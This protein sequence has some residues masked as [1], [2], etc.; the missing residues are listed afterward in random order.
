MI[1]IRTNPRQKT[2][3]PND[4]AIEGLDSEKPTTPPATIMLKRPPMPANTPDGHW[5]PT[6]HA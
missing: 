6:F 3:A 2:K 5:K 1:I 4:V